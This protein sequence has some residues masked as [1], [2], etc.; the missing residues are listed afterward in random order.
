MT[1][2]MVHSWRRSGR[3]DRLLACSYVCL[4]S[5][6][7]CER[8]ALRNPQKDF[9]DVSPA[10]RIASGVVALENGRWLDDF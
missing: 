8:F 7:R 4:A 9:E 10:V 1:Q 5:I 6:K 2:Q 3:S